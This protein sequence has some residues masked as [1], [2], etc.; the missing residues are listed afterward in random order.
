MK[1]F[2]VSLVLLCVINCSVIHSAS[3][4]NAEFNTAFARFQAGQISREEFAQAWD[5]FSQKA[6]SSTLVDTKHRIDQ[7]FGSGTADNLTDI[8]QHGREKR[9]ITPLQQPTKIE[10]K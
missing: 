9:S 5:T 1:K 6:M 4:E 3:P 2:V 7:T 10:T 8:A